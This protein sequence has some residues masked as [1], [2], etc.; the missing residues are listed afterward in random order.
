MEAE[1]RYTYVGIGVLALVAA[2]VFGVVWLKSAGGKGEFARYAIHF[3]RQ[4][5]DG[6]EVGGDVRLRGIKIGRVQDYALVGGKLNR[7]RVEVRVDRR[8]P[9]RTNT[10]AVVTRNFVTGI[11]AITLVTPEPPGEALEEVPEG[12]TYPVIAEGRSDIDELAGRVNQLGDMAA[13]TLSELNQ[14]FNAD[15]RAT[16]MATVRNLR[17]LADGLNKRLTA[18][19]GALARVGSSAAS[20]G[21]AADRL[22]QA[23]ERIAGVADRSAERFDRALAEAERTLLEAQRAMQQVAQASGAVQQQAVAT[24]RRLEDSAARIDDQFGAALVEL[25]LSMETATRALDSLREPRS[26]L[27]GPGKSQLGPGERLP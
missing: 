14:L 20:V 17:D 23:G 19:D 22:G 25:Q 7:V 3:E 24:G 26:A 10:T 13:V 8:A 21:S 27:L 12:E 6:L 11:A 9:V 16:V 15:N 2:L 5:L 18:L 1:A 4:A